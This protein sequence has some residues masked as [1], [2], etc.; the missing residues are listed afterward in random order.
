MI[1]SRFYDFM[2]PMLAKDIASQIGG[3]IIGNEEIS[4]SSVTSLDSAQISDLTYCEE[5]KADG[6]IQTSAG[7]V[8]TKQCL[9][10]KLPKGINAIIVK[11]PRFSF[12][13]FAAGFVLDK[14]TTIDSRTD[15]K[16]ETGA[17]IGAGTIIGKNVEIG[18]NTIIGANSIIS[19]G[20]TIGRNC[21]IGSGVSISAAYIGD[22]VKIGANSVI[23]KSGFG[24]VGGDEGIIDVPQFGRVIIQDSV[25][26]GALCTI[27]RGAF[28]DTVIGMMTKTDNHCHIAHNVKIGKGVIM[29]AYAGISGSVEIGDYVM[30]GGRVGIGDHFKIGTGAKLGAGSAVL[31][32]V[33]AGE[34]YVGYPAKPKAKFLRETI[35]L[36]RLLDKGKR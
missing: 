3:V 9:V 7:L 13:K 35:A 4:I 21:Q 23:G 20:V 30:M 29:A 19:E 27:D 10:D 11:S 18:E 24:V 6:K 1:D 25:T 2:P 15:A 33:P 31:S 28:D 14:Y 36:S 5:W 8:I 17:I 34:T 16:I 22:N 26:I 12:A 32:D